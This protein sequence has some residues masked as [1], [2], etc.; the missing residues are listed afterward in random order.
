VEYDEDKKTRA[1]IR[2]EETVSWQ[3]F[4]E[5]VLDAVED[6]IV[7][8]TD[9]YCPTK[10][11]DSWDLE[12]LQRAVKDSLNVEMGFAPSG[13]REQVQEQIYDVVSKVVQQRQE[14]FGEEFLRFLQYRYLATI[15]GLWK[16]H[17]LG[18]DH[19]RQ[20]IGLR[21]YGQKDPKQEYKKEGYEGFMQML[22]TISHQFVGQLMRVQS[23][24][25]AEETARLQR[26]MAQ[27]AAQAHEGRADAEGR[28]QPE[29]Q[30]ARASAPAPRQAAVREGP[31]VGRND[32]CPCGSGK[33]YKKCH[34]AGEATA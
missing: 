21:G 7:R 17:L 30:A 13:T 22:S 1:K 5:L 32:P 4:Q 25:A 8:M 6:V 23:R 11:P 16:D 18:M 19:L 34:G 10:N 12:G 2:T 28:P 9:V 27:K 14:E 31:R 15:D 29:P 20:G 33:K 3:D 24:N 26:Q